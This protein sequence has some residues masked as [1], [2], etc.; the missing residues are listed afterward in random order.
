VQNRFNDE[1]AELDSFD[2]AMHWVAGIA[3]DDVLTTQAFP[4]V[5]RGMTNVWSE[6]A[7]V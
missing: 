1:C 2:S 6:S 5:P 3:G 7:S 4:M